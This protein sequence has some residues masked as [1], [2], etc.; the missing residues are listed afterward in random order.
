MKLTISRSG[1]GSHRDLQ[2]RAFLDP[3]GSASLFRQGNRTCNDVCA[4]RMLAFT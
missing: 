4:D 2:R 1:A 3:A